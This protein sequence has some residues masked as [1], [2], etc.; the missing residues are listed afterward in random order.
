MVTFDEQKQRYMHQEGSGGGGGSLG[1]SARPADP[2]VP[3]APGSNIVPLI[4]GRAYFPALKAAITA[5]S[6]EGAFLYLAGWWMDV[7]FSLDGPSGAAK[8]IDLLKAKAAAGVDVRVA[9]WVMAPEVLQSRLLRAGLGRGGTSLDGVRNMLRINDFT[10][11]FIDTLR[12]GAG[13]AD[14][15]CLN[16]LSHPAG[17]VH[18]KFALLGN[19]TGATGFTGGLDFRPGRWLPAWHDVQV[20]ATGPVLQGFYDAYRQMWNEIRSRPP[21]RLQG[22]AVTTDS[23][24]AATPD[25]P[26][27]TIAGTGGA[28]MHAQSVRTLPQYNFS[29]VGSVFL[30]TNRPLS[31]APHGLFET[32]PVWRRGIGGAQK[33]LYI[34]DQ[35][36]TAAEVF[37][38]VNAA[39]KANAELRVVLLTGQ[40]DPDDAENDILFKFFTRAINDHLLPGITDL[41]RRVGL[42]T[43][44]TNTIHTKSTIID[45]LWS[46][47]GSANCMRRSLYTDFEHSVAWMDED[48][49]A[50]PAYRE[51]L[52]G[53][54]LLASI[55]DVDTALAAWFAVPFAGTPA[56]ATNAL[57]VVRKTLPLPQVR[58]GPMD[59]SLYD[60]VFDADSRQTWGV[61]LGAAYMSGAGTAVLSP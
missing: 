10:M 29:T 30:P 1:G 13:L 11:T 60:E 46:L 7:A 20:Q 17:A 3:I 2:A 9:G 24:T 49:R 45:D 15:A 31:Y 32:V 37:D 50:I 27:R 47:T 18:M 22:L 53:T 4:H 26:A 57:P 54:H 44:K 56:A 21:V 43:H 8:L 23:H 42:F 16:I 38:W 51:S 52:W 61:A 59:Q 28:R 36:F 19:T 5:L 58:L 48:A 34:E 39:L 6:G 14:K 33:Y 40:A 12:A 41:N 35:G 55:P 25:I